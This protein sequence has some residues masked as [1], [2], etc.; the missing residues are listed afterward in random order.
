MHKFVRVNKGQACPPRL[1]GPMQST[2]KSG[3]LVI[4]EAVERDRT[5]KKDLES[6]WKRRKT[7]I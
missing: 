4:A 1:K 5:A 6:S 7:C 2:W 3:K